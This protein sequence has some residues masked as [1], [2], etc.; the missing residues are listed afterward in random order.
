MFFMSTASP[1]YMGKWSGL[2]YVNSQQKTMP[3]GLELDVIFQHNEGNGDTALYQAY[4]MPVTICVAFFTGVLTGTAARYIKGPS[5]AR[6][7][8]DSIFWKVPEDF[9]NTEDTGGGADQTVN[10]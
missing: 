8:S 5:V 2:A 4:M 9:L 6:T 10:V 3:Y 1:R 7:F